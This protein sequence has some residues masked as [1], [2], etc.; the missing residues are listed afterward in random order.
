MKAI[1]YFLMTLICCCISR[2]PNVVKKDT[3]FEVKVELDS[4]PLSAYG[5]K[6]RGNDKYDVGDYNGA[7]EDYT[8]AIMVNPQYDTAYYNR[9]NTRADLGD[10]KGAIDDYNEAIRINP[11]YLSPYFNRG[12]TKYEL[13]DYEGE[14]EDYRL[15]IQNCAPAADLYNNLGR[16]LYDLERFKESA[17]AYGDGISHFPEDY[18]LYYGRGLARERL[19]DRKGACEDWRKS[20]ALGCVEA[21]TLL[22]LCEECQTE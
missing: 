13:G 12:F 19:G 2:Q 20:S 14:I 21:N 6:M 3:N 11:Q 15:A 10:K 7:Y 16:A 18:K 8:R 1:L 22:P 9:G 17:E 5:Y 4:I